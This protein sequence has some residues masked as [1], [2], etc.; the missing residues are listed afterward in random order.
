MR[1]RRV[2]QL[3]GR[4]GVCEITA[5][6][7]APE[8]GYDP[9]SLR[10]AGHRGR[11]RDR[12]LK[13]GRQSLSDHELLELLLTYAIPR[14]DV[15][16]AAKALLLQ[17]GSL[18]AVLLQSPETLRSAGGLG[19]RSAALIL[20]T[21]ELMA[22]SLELEAHSGLKISCPED[23][24]DLVRL[25]LGPEPR[26]CLLLLCLNTANQLIRQVRLA[27]GTVNQAPVYPREVVQA[28]LDHGATAVILVHNH[29]GGQCAPSR[30][31]LEITRSLSE[32]LGKLDIRLHDHLIVTSASVYS[33]MG[34][35]EVTFTGPAGQ[36][37][38][39]E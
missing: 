21:R 37:A 19:P 3:K 24:A 27:R 12:F 4:T 22:R 35:R 10:G 1:S 39:H 7:Q 32:T 17:H 15:K 13:G 5:P 31:D 9:R 18:A 8:A 11:L 16:P 26:E 34:G 25:E 23:V 38:A 14:R 6:G 33:I 2:N 28:A 36:A 30:E 20:L 29:P